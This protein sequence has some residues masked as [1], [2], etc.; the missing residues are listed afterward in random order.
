VSSTQKLSKLNEKHELFALEFVARGLRGLEAAHKAAGFAGTRQTAHQLR[1][2]PL[3]KKRIAELMAEKFKALHMD[4][5]E[6][7]ARTASIAR[8]DVRGLFDEDGNMR[9]PGDLDEAEAAAIAGIEVVEV[10]DG[11]GESKVKT[12][13]VKKVR[14]RDPM[15]ALRLLAEYKK[16]VKQPDDGVNALASALAERMKAARERQR[17]KKETKR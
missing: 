10:F 17:T 11:A 1:H 4:V 9:K 8:A 14:L 2:D 16:L 5:D 3:I 15:P 12:G 7:L 13:E 6:I